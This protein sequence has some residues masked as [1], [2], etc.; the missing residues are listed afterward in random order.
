M[1]FKIAFN[2]LLEILPQSKVDGILKLTSLNGIASLERSKE[3]DIS[4]LGNSKYKSLVSKS[5][6]SVILLPKDYFGS[7]KDN[8]VFIRMDEPSRGLA[9]LCSHLETQLYPTPVA[10][11]HSTAWVDS[12]AKLGAGVTVGAFS[13]I[14]KDVY[15][16][17]NCSIA[18]HCHIGDYS[19]VGRNSTLHPGVK[20]LSRCELGNGV[21]VNAGAVIG[22]EGYGFDQVEGSHRKIPHIGTVVIEDDVEIGANT[23]IDRS[24]FEETRIGVGSKIDNLVQIGHNVRMG[25]GCLIVA[26]VGIAGSVEFDD[27]VVVGGQAGFAGHL[28][29]GKGAKIAGQAG[30]TKNVEPGAFLKGNPALPFQLAQRI[31]ILQKRLP[32]LFNR[33]DGLAVKE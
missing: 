30:I 1:E 24:R 20:L 28:K 14:G 27:N 29:I 15:I 31:S 19:K 32:E 13:F 18:T 21:I 25:K 26:Q 22:S 33:F 16:E 17:D 8:Q 6:A 7:P 4:F 5:N 3:G 2:E 11:I 9:S 12:T 10:E 23:C